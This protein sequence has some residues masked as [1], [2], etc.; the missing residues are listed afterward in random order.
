VHGSG[1]TA[2]V[3]E[4]AREA[5]APVSFRIRAGLVSGKATGV[6]RVR[7]A[8][9]ALVARGRVKVKVP[10]RTVTRSISQRIPVER[11]PVAECGLSG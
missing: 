3:L 4:P 2:F 10:F 6:L 9:G 8:A 11:G 5:T 7:A 1:E